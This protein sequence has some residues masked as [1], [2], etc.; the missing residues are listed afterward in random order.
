MGDLLA[1]SGRAGARLQLTAANDLTVG[2]S[3][4]P[5]LDEVT[6]L[7]V[8]MLTEITAPDALARG[9]GIAYVTPTEVLREIMPELAPLEVCPYRGLEPFTAE[10]ARWFQGREEAVGQVLA[11]LD[12]QQ[13]LTLLLGPS[14]SGKSS[15]IQAGV[16][17]ALA[18]GEVP[19]SDRWLPVLARPRQDLPAEIERA[20]LP[21][22][23][24]DG[25][26]AAVGRRLRSEPDHHR[27][28][29]VVDQFEELLLQSADGRLQEFLATVDDIVQVADTFTALSVILVMR[30]D[31][32]PQLAAL[33]PRLLEA[34]T[35]G[36][37]NVPGT[38]SRRDLHDIIVKPA[39]NV[40]LRFQPGLPEQI[41][42]DVL[43]SRPEPAA[44]RRAPVTVLPLLEMTLKQLWLRRHDG[45]LTHEAYRQI[46]AV[47]GSLT[48]WCDSALDELSP[49][50]QRIARRV[51]TCLVQPADRSRRTP[52][53]RAQ[54][55]LDELR[56]L[57][58]GPDGAP[59]GDFDAVIAALTRHRLITTQTLRDPDR[60]AA[61]PGEPVAELIHDA[62][63]RDWG[64]LRKW[65]EE[66][67]Q[68]QEWLNRTWERQRRWAGK[69]DPG[70]LLAGTALAEGFD[71]SR[72]RGL[73]EDIAA[74]LTASRKRQQ[75]LARRRRHL[76]AVL[77]T[78][79]GLAL[80]AA[81][82]AVL[83]WRAAVDERQAALSRQLATQ[84]RTLL[85]VS[86]DLSSLLA[87]QA[88]R[89][90]HT[91][92]ALASLRTDASLPA[93]R[94]LPGHTDTVDSVAFSPDGRTL[95]TG[96]SD[97]TARLWDT[98]TGTTRAT[99]R[100]HPGEV[101]SAAFSPD[102]HT[103][104]TASAD[105]ARLWDTAT[106]KTRAT[107]PVS[108]GGL[109]SLA[110]SP[111]GRTLAAA[112]GD[113][114][115]RLWDTATG[116]TRTP[117]TGHDSTV[118]SVA[119]SPDGRTLAT[120]G[121]DHTG[122][123]WDTETGA[124]RTTLNGHTDGVFTIAFS[125]DGHAVATGSAD[126]TMKVWHAATGKMRSSLD[127]AT[128]AVRALAFSRDGRT[129]A[130][131][132]TN[133][134]L[135]LWDVATGAI[136]GTLIGHTDTVRSVAFS[137]DGHTLASA[138]DDRTTRLWDL[139]PRGDRPLV[140]HT[141]LVYDVAFSPDGRTLASGSA[142]ETVRLWDVTS[143]A[144]RTVLTGHT[145][146]VL[147]VDFSPDGRSLATSGVD[148]TVRLWDV[149]TGKTRAVLED[150][151]ELVAVAFSPDGRTLATGSIDGTVMLWDAA[152]GRPRATFPGHTG[153]VGTVA[154][155]PDGR[156]LASG[157]A[158]KSVRLWD[159]AT[160][161]DRFTGRT[162]DT[163]QR[164]VF[165]PDG[166]ILAT[167]MGDYSVR[168]LDA[169]TGKTRTTLAGRTSQ[170]AS[171]A[172]SPDGRTLATADF[173]WTTGL[174]DTDSGRNRVA[175][176][177]QHADEVTSVAFSP[178]GRTLASGSGDRTVRLWRVSLPTPSEAIRKICHAVNRDL[179][180]QER[181][182]YLP[183][184]SSGPVC[185]TRR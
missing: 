170:A 31:F 151:S 6:G 166:R 73:P 15:L 18:R 142:D 13:R 1:P 26:M 179:D 138:S 30:D 33:A 54:V 27:V 182:A 89:A 105:G 70:D 122:R 92:E 60:P 95:A 148:A 25:L 165:S 177:G 158:D 76:I 79:L 47:S 41:I 44:V 146:P 172:F 184:K 3:G 58:A 22:T 157:S 116:A 168:L 113:G 185:P 135:R 150:P 86:P 83:Q 101:A 28:L 90:S 137:P 10:D 107:L 21:G 74:F 134:L 176:I 102:G 67:R 71:Q 5:V 8:G 154:F 141:G 37:L 7:V 108:A 4:G 126:G 36:L 106:G 88:Y 40:R 69:R 128:G 12:R 136:S 164:V 34:A 162:S 143:G 49:R 43:A 52:A 100:G 62:L 133:R 171:V 64:A 159:V 46:G 114:T 140:G 129:L 139:T 98:A 131:G 152:T 183:G 174:W 24:R 144:T 127:V 96:S 14:G 50:R 2:F 23:R 84:S 42:S 167:T 120:A 181:T 111:D 17:P 45:Y 125:P 72:D 35:P 175:L 57:A 11:G 63:I 123:L 169:A 53:V 91:P 132:G 19:G 178:D 66:D 117:L 87:V 82:I 156:T 180:A 59:G 173:D 118:F 153:Y 109:F 94:R 51:L 65:V 48:T 29:L 145:E 32:Y 112:G 77:A 110:F 155:S 104:A 99:L 85:D 39:E 97:G 161:K 160:R 163:V 9:Q 124:P 16:L 56:D 115:V 147:Q 119:F 149:T 103:L 55:P 93:Y 61:P 80:I 75:V 121:A 130:I 81:G 20:G 78:L 38:L 68:F